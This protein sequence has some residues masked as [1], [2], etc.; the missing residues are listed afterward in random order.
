ME[1]TSKIIQP[2]FSGRRVFNRG[3]LGSPAYSLSGY[4]MWAI[5]RLRGRTQTPAVEDAPTAEKRVDDL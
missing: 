5:Q 3:G 2:F 4:V 1:Y